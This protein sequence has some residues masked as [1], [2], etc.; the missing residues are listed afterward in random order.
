MGRKGGHPNVTTVLTA[1]VV[2]VAMLIG[3]AFVSLTVLREY[4]RGVSSVWATRVLCTNP[5]WCS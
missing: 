4:E 2:G 5:G 1:V 3:L